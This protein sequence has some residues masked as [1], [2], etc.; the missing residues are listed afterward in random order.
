VL[1]SSFCAF[2][3][4]RLRGIGRD[5]W[6]Y[7]LLATMMLPGQVTMIPVY[8]IFQKI[9]WLNTFKPLIVPAWFGEAYAIFLMRQFFR[10][11]P[12][13]LEESAYVD[14]ANTVQIIARI[15]VPLSIPVLTVIGILSFK[16]IWTDFMGPLFYL[17]EQS[18]YTVSIGLA[19][20]NGQNDTKMNLLMAASVTM[21][22]PT[23]I[24]FFIA[25]RAFVQGITMTGLKG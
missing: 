15:I 8:L 20:L 25:Q 16:D 2:G 21:M 4:A 18:K 17:N 9:G 1:S 11:I 23:L 13:E 24:L 12:K 14:G 6:F 7:I 10:T 22:M 5:F 19:Y 3:F